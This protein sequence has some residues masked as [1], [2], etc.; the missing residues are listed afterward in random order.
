MRGWFALLLVHGALLLEWGPTFLAAQSPG[1][2]EANLAVSIEGQVAVKRPGWTN[3]SPVVFGTSLRSGDLLRIEAASSIKIVCSD[4]TLREIPVGLGGVPCESSRPVL[5]RPDGSMV[6]PTRGWSNDGSFPVVL[7]PRKTKLLSPRPLIRWTPVPGVTS[8]TVIVRSADLYWASPV[9]SDRPVRYPFSA[10]QLKPGQDYKVIVATPRGRDS[11]AEPGVGLGFA[12]LSPEETRTVLR[13]E[14]QIEN[15]GLAEGPTKF[16]VAHLYASHGLRAEAIEELEAISEKFKVAAVTR[17][18]GDLYL[19]IGLTRQAEASYLSTVEQA[20]SE[21]DEIGQMLAHLALARIY[22]QV[23]GNKEAAT[24][25]F[26]AALAMANKLGDNYTA[27]AAGQ[28]L[29]ELRRPATH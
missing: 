26:D 6:K 4:L 27:N 21:K 1:R 19:S 24:E 25:H 3:Y 29:G 23:L 18:L 12:V 10:P 9:S 7:S 2:E 5:L 15:L 28:G 22:E 17:L 11:S 20:K 14:K 16:L 8:Y 13:E